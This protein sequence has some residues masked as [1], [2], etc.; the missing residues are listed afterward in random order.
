MSIRW[1]RH[2]QESLESRSLRNY[3]ADKEDKWEPA[4]GG[5]RVTL[6]F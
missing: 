5:V 1:V 6:I 2:Q 4:V 3:Q